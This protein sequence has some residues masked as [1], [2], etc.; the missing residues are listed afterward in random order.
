MKLLISKKNELL[1]LIKE[2]GLS[3]TSFE[4]K[5]EKHLTKGTVLKTTIL[6]KNQ[7]SLYFSFEVG[8]LHNEIVYFPS[9]Y[10]NKRVEEFTIWK[11]AVLKFKEWI[12]LVKIELSSE[13]EW[14]K[15]LLDIKS[16]NQ[17]IKAISLT[18]DKFTLS[19]KN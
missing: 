16:L 17:K 4:Y 11:L 12:D 1:Q 14:E 3:P 18:D 13:V 5:I 6:A 10:G 2:A 19:S 15:M 8:P 7:L 9:E